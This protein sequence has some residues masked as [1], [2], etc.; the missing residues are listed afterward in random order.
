MRLNQSTI[1]AKYKDVVDVVD[2][3]VLDYGDAIGRQDVVIRSRR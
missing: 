1:L 2:V 3:V